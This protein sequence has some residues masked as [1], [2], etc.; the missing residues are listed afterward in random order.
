MS[1]LAP[2]VN[3]TKA[4]IFPFFATAYFW[5]LVCNLVFILFW[6]LAKNKMWLLSFLTIL[7]G[8]QHIGSYLS[9]SIDRSSTDDICI[10]TYNVGNQILR[11]KKAKKKEY[12]VAFKKFLKD[13]ANPNILCLQETWYKNFY[14]CLLYTS[15]SPRDQRGSRMP[16]SA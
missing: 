14:S 7:L 10:M 13:Q 9:V 16:S 2:Y 11:A 12:N 4:W 1:Y 3:P 6:A 15:P 5:L 8:L